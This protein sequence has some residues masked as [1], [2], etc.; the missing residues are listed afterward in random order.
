MTARMLLLCLLCACPLYARLLVNP[1]FEDTVPAKTAGYRKELFPGW[2]ILLNSGAGSCDAAVSED[3]FSGGKSLRL[4]S[5]APRGFVSAQ[6]V[7]P[8]AVQ[9]GDRVTG[10]VMVKGEGKAYIRFYYLD[11]EGQRVAD[12][13]YHM[14]GRRAQPE[15]WQELI[16]R[17]TVPEGVSA[18]RFSLQ[19]LQQGAICFDAAKV[20]CDRDAILENEHLRVAFNPL[21]GGVVDS[22]L[23]KSTGFEFTRA[24]SRQVVGGLAADIV[25]GRRSPGLCRHEVYLLNREPG[26]AGSLTLQRKIDTAPLAG[27][28]VSKTFTLDPRKPEL[29]VKLTLRN[30]GAEAL[31]ASFRTQNIVLADPGVFSWPHPDWV[32]IFRQQGPITSLNSIVTENFR[33]GWAARWYSGPQATLLFEFDAGLVEKNYTYLADDIS[34][35]EWYYREANLAPGQSWSTDYRIKVLPGADSFF[36][37]AHGRTQKVE[38]ILP[39]AM[40]APPLSAPLPERLQ[41]F[42]PYGAH[43]GNLMLPEMVGARNPK[44]ELYRLSAERIVRDYAAACFNFVYSGHLAFDGTQKVLWEDDGRNVIGELAREL[45]LRVALSKIMLHR[46]DVE[47]D[48]Y[49]PKLEKNLE[50]LKTEPVQK[51]LRQYEDVNACFFSGDEILPKNA[52]AMLL[53]H[54]E[55]RKVLPEGVIP[56][57][58]LN[59]SSHGLMPYLPVYFG[60]FYPIKRK[61]AS[62]RNPWSVYREFSSL[63]KMAGAT[64]VWFM[65]QAFGYRKHTYALATAGEMRLMVNL[66]VA[67]GVRGIVFHGFANGGWS[68]RMNYYYDYSIYGSAGQRTEAWQ[69]IAECGRDITALG[70]ELW[71]ARPAPLP[72]GVAVACEDF[73]E[74]NGLY[75]GPALTAHALASDRGRFLL[76]VNQDPVQ[77]RRGRLSAAAPLY[78]LS[79]DRQLERECDLEL[80]PGGGRYFL[81]DGHHDVIAAVAAARQTR[82]RA[83]QRALA[84]EPAGLEEARA[85]LDRIDFEFTRHLDILVTPEMREATAR[86]RRWVANP[87]S[88]LEDLMTRIAE[89]FYELNRLRRTPD[90]TP[91]EIAQFT[92]RVRADA[93]LAD[94]QLR[95]F[96]GNPEIDDPY[97]RK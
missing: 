64:P 84:R 8:V 81:L 32:Q 33:A 73:Q 25:P 40:P 72:D 56:F 23:L 79:G 37:D 15:S 16:T 20:I 36:V 55:L 17:F 49:R 77:A 48:A 12:Q 3:A 82:S 52:E 43:L 86:Y 47:P 28:E 1:D 90:A 50:M 29:T 41:G 44:P 97:E 51:F 83:A 60:D 75:R 14:E 31:A 42:F 67:A 7:P 59:S 63:V 85:L 35:V 6:A 45:D 24:N 80:P 27:L 9:A 66:A 22:L 92:S 91:A 61:D 39:R 38:E 95:R 34:T 21:C 71:H 65:P 58:Y 54:A 4:I 69:A 57:P 88:A 26:A 10:K 62:G 11:A 94:A 5:M 74:A 18:V 89:D 68:W 78:D 19:M 87:D 76:V 53:A 13:G 46:E 2:E 93:E 70:A 96:A 30:T